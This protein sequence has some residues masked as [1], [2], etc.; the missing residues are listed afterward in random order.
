LGPSSEVVIVG[1]LHEKD[2]DEFLRT[3]RSRFLPRKVVLFRSSVDQSPE[4]AEL[5]SFIKNLQREHAR[6]TAVVC[7]NHVCN[8]PTTNAS[9]MLEM[10]EQ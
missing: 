5:T 1:D 2:T 3:I 4:I 7:R 6:A 9:K 8:L 10:L